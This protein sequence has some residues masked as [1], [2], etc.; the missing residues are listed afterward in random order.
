MSSV[1]RYWSRKI[2]FLK[3]EKTTLRFKLQLYFSKEETT[4]SMDGFFA[5][6][7]V[8]GMLKKTDCKNI[9]LYFNV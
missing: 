3:T 6:K 2:I 7:S 9:D 4:G 1:K 5:K 8:L